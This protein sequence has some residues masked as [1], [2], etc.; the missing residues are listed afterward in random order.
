MIGAAAVASMP[1]NCQ[2][3]HRHDRLAGTCRP[4]PCHRCGAGAQYGALGLWWCSP[5]FL[6]AVPAS[7][8]QGP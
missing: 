7:E 8:G 2:L 4:Y 1:E 5:C 3:E 6:A